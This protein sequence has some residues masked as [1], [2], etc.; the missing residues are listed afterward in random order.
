MNNKN[1]KQTSRF[2]SLLLRHKPET[3]GL[4]L[5]ENGWADMD[6][7]IKKSKKRGLT[8]ALIER[9][10][11][12]DDK[13]RFSIEGN[14]IRANQGHSLAIDLGLKAVTPPEV[15]YHGTAI[16][17]LDSIMKMGLTKQ[18]RQYVHLSKEIETATHV[19]MRHGK[20]VILEVD[21]KGM[22][23]AGYLFYL[24]EN[25]VWLTDVVPKEFLREMV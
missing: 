19:G 16:R 12:Q 10:V 7:L 2:L 17:F 18:K 8:R 13:Q 1:I 5:D 3:I 6:E 22:Y 23:E 25:G 11:E 24:S 14:R 9:V 15:L 4:K 21:A 20:V